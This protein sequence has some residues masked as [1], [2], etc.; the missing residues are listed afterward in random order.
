MRM[1]WLKNKY[2]D[3]KKTYKIGI[4]SLS[5]GDGYREKVKLGRETKVRYCQKHKYEFIED[6]SVY[7][8]NRPIAWSKILL[9]KKYLKYYDY[10]VWMD[11]DTNIM[12]DE[13]KLE[14]IIDTYA[15]NRDILVSRDISGE[16][17][18][19]VMFV[20]NTDFTHRVL[21]LVYAQEQFVNDKYW[22]QTAFNYIYNNN[23][24][25]TLNIGEFSI[26][27]STDQQ[28]LFNCCVGLYKEG[29]FLIHF[30]GPRD[31]NWVEKAMNDFCPF[32]RDGESDDT[33]N[34]RLK[35][36]RNR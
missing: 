34:A 11:A 17:N 35:W 23:I 5:I 22:E 13:I 27:L 21:D 1:N 14:D 15:G 20:K 32:Q 4:C 30:Y 18:T 9:L 31:I 25:A 8:T 28:H 12:N 3:Y 19:G 2:P 7:D 16:I 29:V 6:A 26:V 33:F 36:I 10:L 24:D